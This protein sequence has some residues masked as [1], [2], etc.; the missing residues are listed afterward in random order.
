MSSKI[1]LCNGGVLLRGDIDCFTGCGNKRSCILVRALNPRTQVVE[2]FATS[3]CVCQRSQMESQGK[4]WFDVDMDVAVISKW[5]AG[6]SNRVLSQEMFD[7]FSQRSPTLSVGGLRP[8]KDEWRSESTQKIEN[9]RSAKIS[10]AWNPL[11]DSDVCSDEIIGRC[12][13][14]TFRNRIERK[15]DVWKAFGR[16]AEYQDRRKQDLQRKL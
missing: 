12:A 7:E 11:F 10:D 13:A 5:V 3:T 6:K 8:G 14:N 1:N 15:P 16:D 4:T 2:C 9:A